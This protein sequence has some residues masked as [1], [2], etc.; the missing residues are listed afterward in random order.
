M[1]LHAK[2]QEVSLRAK[3]S[4]TLDPGYGSTALMLAESTLC[5]ALNRS[6]LTEHYGV[7]TP[8]TAM[9]EPLLQRLKEAGMKW[10]VN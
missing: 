4:H 6:S 1:Y 10:E 7:L 5:L 3:V 9:G 8:S 2:R